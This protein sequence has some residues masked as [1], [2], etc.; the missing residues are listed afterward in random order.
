MKFIYILVILVLSGCYSF[1]KA[2]KQHGRAVATFPT[3][4]ADYCA[5]VYPP[6]DSVIKGDSVIVIDTLTLPGTVT[7]DTVQVLGTDTIRITKTVTLPAKEIIK[8][9]YIHDTA[10]VV[11]R[12]ALDACNIE[13]RQLTAALGTEQARADKYQSQARTRGWALLGLLAAGG[14]WLYFKFTRKK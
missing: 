4:G 6:Q 1:D 9:V 14:V 10:L 5:R 12:A 11:D 13:K 3:I 7:T 8:T 2:N